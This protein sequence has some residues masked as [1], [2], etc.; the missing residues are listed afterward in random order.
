ME[1]FY[2]LWTPYLQSFNLVFK[3]TDI[4]I[5]S[6]ENLIEKAK[7]ALLKYRLLIENYGNKNPLFLTTLKPYPE[8]KKAPEIIQ[9]MIKE[10]KKVGVGPMASVAGAIADFV[11][12]EL[13]SET[14]EIIIENG[15]DIFIKA[16]ERKKIGIWCGK[17]SKIKKI[18]F[19]VEPKDTPLGICTSSA[20]I[21]HS[22]SF[23]STDAT[24]ILA[25]NA[26]LADACATKVANIVKDERDII[27]GIEFAKKIPGVK[28][29]IIVIGNKI[30]CWGKIK[31]LEFL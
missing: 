9:K 21:G 30:A 7:I 3:E 20:K 22:L 15:G 24:T 26:T 18:V 1:K 23:G 4:Q 29:V 19:E 11:G 5:Y 25:K 12:K 10:S 16:K 13:L 6:K 17:L 28:G 8:D 14:K 31:N 2:R 27:E